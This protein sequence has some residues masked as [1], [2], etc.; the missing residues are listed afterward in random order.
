MKSDDANAKSVHLSEPLPSTSQCSDTVDSVD[1]VKS[2]LSNQEAADLEYMSCTEYLPYT[3]RPKAQEIPAC[4]NDVISE[5]VIVNVGKVAQLVNRVHEASCE[6]PR[7]KVHVVNRMGLCVS[8]AV[9]CNSCNF[10]LEPIQMSD[11]VE[12]AKGPPAGALNELAVMPAVKTKMGLTDITTVLTC[13]NIKAPSRTAMQKKFNALCDKMAAVNERQLIKNQEYLRQVTS[14]L[15]AVSGIDTQYDVSYSSRPQGGSE[16]AQQSFAAIIEHTT[17]RKLPI[18]AAVANKH[19]RRKGCDHRQ[20]KCRKT[21]SSEKSIAASERSLLNET[22]N[23]VRTAGLITL[24]SVTTDASTQLAKALRE[25][26]AENNM[27]FSHYKC[28][29]HRGRTLEKHIRALK[30][31]SIPK[32]YDRQA[33]M[34]KLASCL[35]GR[36]RMELKNARALIKGDGSFIRAGAAAVRVIIKCLSGDHRHCKGTSFVCRGHLLTYSTNCLPYGMHLQLNN[37]DQSLIEKELEKMFNEDGLKDM[38]KLFNTNMVESLHSTVYRLAPKS[39]CY[40]RNFPALCHSAVHSTS[41]GQSLSTLQLAQAAGLNV[42]EN[43]QMYKQLRLKDRQRKYDSKRRASADYKQRRYYLRK[44]KSNRS[45][46]SNSLYSIGQ[47]ASPMAQEHNY[48]L[49]S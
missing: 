22:L 44:K 42:K 4:E 37:K 11:T 16:K 15:P 2:R 20:D 14:L 45:L 19:C 29:I 6:N 31:C 3:L 8:F 38:C 21:Y 25:Y 34:Q 17:T 28:F 1:S 23:N 41:V 47:E 26:K 12:K 49:T 9:K 18:A 43:S 48:G 24:R 30:L 13:L 10:S 35:R 39:L 7:V 33:Y 36:V 27:N 32:T 5:N 46:F 40:S